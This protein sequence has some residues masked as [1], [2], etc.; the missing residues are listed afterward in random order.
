MLPDSGAG[1]MGGQ[2]NGGPEPDVARVPAILSQ[3]QCTAIEDT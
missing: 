3:S 1:L 2:E